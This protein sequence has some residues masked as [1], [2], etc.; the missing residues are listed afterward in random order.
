MGLAAVMMMSM[1]AC[2]GNDNGISS[3]TVTLPYSM[4]AVLLR[5]A[6]RRVAMG[7]PTISVFASSYSTTRL[8]LRQKDS[9]MR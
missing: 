7:K 9:K 8:M 5:P 6:I 2:G 4:E 1:T 3:H